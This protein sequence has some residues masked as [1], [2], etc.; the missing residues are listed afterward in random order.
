MDTMNATTTIRQKGTRLL[1]ALHSRLPPATRQRIS[2]AVSRRDWLRR[3]VNRL[4]AGSLDPA[5]LPPDFDWLAYVRMHPDLHHLKTKGEAVN[6]YLASGRQEHRRYK[7]DLPAWISSSAI[8]LIDPRHLQDG[9]C[10]IGY[11]HSEIGLGQAARNLACAL[12]GQRYPLSFKNLP[13][14]GRENEPEFKTKTVGLANRKINL[15]V[16]GLPSVETREPETGAGT[17]T[18]LYPFWELGKIP[19]PWLAKLRQYDEIWVPSRFGAQAFPADFPVPVRLM[20]L[21]VRRL[22]WRDAPAPRSRD[23]DGRLRCFTFF[24]F[25]SYVARKNPQAAVAAFQAAFPVSE[26][27]VQLTV[28]AR[29]GNDQGLRRWLLQ[30]AAKDPRIQVI[31]QTL[32]R[33]EMDRLMQDCDVFISLHRSEGFGFGVADALAA[34]KAV[35]STHYSATCDFVTPATGYPVDCD[36]VPVKAGEYP[37]AAGQVWAEPRLE[38]AINALRSIQAN[39]E[40]ARAKG[41]AGMQMMDTAYAPEV[42]GRQMT[43][44]LREIEARLAAANRPVS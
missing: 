21:P 6:H 22:E 9:L 37:G 44:C 35:V 42:V 13:L 29:G 39:R 14:P 43:A 32:G 27:A 23:E 15:V 8:H 18:I 30:V 33:A 40:Q 41:R 38:S 11:L 10:L 19:E 28:K 24:D 4:N 12:D 7:S 36:L 3:L 5:L 2:A 20:P 16:L 31:D 34:G 25:D 17:Y 26:T 1:R